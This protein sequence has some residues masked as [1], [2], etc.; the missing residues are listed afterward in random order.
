MVAGGSQLWWSQLGR[1][2][3]QH[4]KCRAASCR[5]GNRVRCAAA[6]AGRCGASWGISIPADGTTW[7]PWPSYNATLLQPATSADAGCHTRRHLK[8]VHRWRQRLHLSRCRAGMKPC[9]GRGGWHSS[10]G[11]FAATSCSL[12]QRHLAGRAHSLTLPATVLLLQPLLQN[13]QILKP[14]ELLFLKKKGLKV[15]KLLSKAMM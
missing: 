1:V 11:G 9:G 13:N 4:R 5:A 2:P 3:H 6:D 10:Q 7:P 8:S 15:R 14:K 12:L